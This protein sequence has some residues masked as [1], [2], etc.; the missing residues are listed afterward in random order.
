[1]SAAA[2]LEIA[3]RIHCP[4]SEG[5]K[6]AA[7]IKAEI[8]AIAKTL[9]APP[10]CTIKVERVTQ[11]AQRNEPKPLT[12]IYENIGTWG[13]V[14]ETR[15]GIPRVGIYLGQGVVAVIELVE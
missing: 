2:L 5:G 3:S 11:W 13:I 6:Y 4:D 9:T 10:L 1:M 7:G 12:A 14:A 15:M 8:E